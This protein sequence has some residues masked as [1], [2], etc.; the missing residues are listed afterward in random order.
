MGNGFVNRHQGL[1]DDPGEQVGQT[2]VAE[3]DEIA[4]GLAFKTQKT[5]GGARLL[6]VGKEVAGNLQQSHGGNTA[7]QRAHARQRGNGALREKVA[8]QA[9]DV[10]RPGLAI[11]QTFQNRDRLL[12]RRRPASALQWMP[13]T[14]QEPMS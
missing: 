8:Y 5:E 14:A 2:T 1:H 9:V 12:L 6:G 3:N 13:V 7:R 4:G 10:C 11:F